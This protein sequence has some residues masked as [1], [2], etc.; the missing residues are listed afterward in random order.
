MCDSSTSPGFRGFPISKLRFPTASDAKADR[1]R[2]GSQPQAC[3]NPPSEPDCIAIGTLPEIRSGNDSAIAFLFTAVHA[4]A[5]I[6]SVA[7]SSLGHQTRRLIRMSVCGPDLL[8]PFCSALSAS[9]GAQ[10]LTTHN[11]GVFFPPRTSPATLPTRCCSASPP[12]PLPSPWA[13]LPE[14]VSRLVQG[15]RSGQSG[16]GARPSGMRPDQVQTVL[17][18]SSVAARQQIALQRERRRSRAHD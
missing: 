3:R 10:S 1:M 12:P 7:G 11:I 6:P 8:S 4:S 13:A 18:I 5:Q 17:R 16:S 15:T 14:M 2:Y 9:P